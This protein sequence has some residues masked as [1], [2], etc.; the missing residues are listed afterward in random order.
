MFQLLQEN[1]I[2]GFLL[3]TSDVSTFAG[4]QHPRFSSLNHGCFNF[5]LIF[6][7]ITSISD[8]LLNWGIFLQE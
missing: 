2:R 3:L 5:L 1:N 4:K 7:Y 6:G 8:I